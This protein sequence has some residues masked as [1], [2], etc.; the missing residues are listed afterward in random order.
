MGDKPLT[1]VGSHGTTGTNSISVIDATVEDASG[2]LAFYGFGNGVNAGLSAASTARL[3]YN[4]TDKKAQLSIDAGAYEDLATNLNSFGSIYV[5][6]GSTGQVPDVDPGELV[7]GF[8]TNGLDAGSV[9]AVAA[10]DKITVGETGN[11]FVS[12]SCSFS[13]T[14]N[15]TF[16]FYV[17]VG[18]SIVAGLRLVRKLGGGGD[19]GS[20]C[21]QGIVSAT[22]A[23]DIEVFVF[24][25]TAPDSF[26][27]VEANLVVTR[28]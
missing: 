23:D 15:A 11:Y 12:L 1:S 21:L 25:G 16:T 14:A 22:A 2:Q 24:G 20:A 19:V 27:L 18:G 9:T 8:T 7:T 6:G 26:T 5:T 13:G 3:R 4:N 17:K 28:L 10:S